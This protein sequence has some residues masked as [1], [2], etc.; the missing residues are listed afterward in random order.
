M[1]NKTRLSLS[2]Y[3]AALAVYKFDQSACTYNYVNSPKQCLHLE[4][5]ADSRHER[6]GESVVTV[7]H[8]KGRLP[9]ARVAHDERLIH[10]VEVGVHGRV[11]ALHVLAQLSRHGSLSRGRREG[12]AGLLWTIESLPRTLLPDLAVVKKKSSLPSLF[13]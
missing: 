6:W 9:D 3:T 13:M 1:S 10:V 12:K 8:Q 7:T 2:V 4:I 11:E 5:Y